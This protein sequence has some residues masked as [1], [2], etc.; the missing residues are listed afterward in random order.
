MGK[1]EVEGWVQ[2]HNLLDTSFEDF[3]QW[4][5]GSYV[6]FALRVDKKTLP[7]KLF[8]AT[9]DVRCRNWCAERGTER[10]PASVKAR[11]REELEDEWLKKALPKASVTEL[12]WHLDEGW[13]LSTGMSVKATDALTRRFH[14]TFGMRLLPWSP[15]DWVP[16]GEVDAL[17]AVGGEV[18]S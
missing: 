11:L 12:C 16:A 1:E 14:R 6:L 9:L 17:L 7:A 15:V 4:L 2:V 5:Y 10:C 18:A 13:L 8:K 3:N